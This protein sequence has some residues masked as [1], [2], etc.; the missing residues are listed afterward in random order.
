MIAREA[1]HEQESTFD[2][3]KSGARRM[4]KGEK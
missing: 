1:C 4:V 3:L 2:K